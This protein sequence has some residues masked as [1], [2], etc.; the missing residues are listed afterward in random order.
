[1]LNVGIFPDF[2]KVSKHI[3]LHKKDNPVSFSNYRPISLLLSISKIFEKAIFKQ[4]V[5]DLEE[6]NL[7][8]K[9]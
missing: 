6:N 8:Y 9:Y 2:P 1:M 7:M 3:P 5:D 4:L